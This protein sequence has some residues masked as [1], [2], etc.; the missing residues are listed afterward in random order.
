MGPL[1]LAA[2]AGGAL[3]WFNSRKPKRNVGTGDDN[4]VIEIPDPPTD[5]YKPGAV[6]TITL[7]VEDGKLFARDFEEPTSVAYTAGVFPVIASATDPWL[8]RLEARHGIEE[9]V[10]LDA[11][12]K[13]LGRGKLDAL[14]ELGL[15]VPEGAPLRLNDWVLEIAVK[16]ADGRI[17]PTYVY[18]V[19]SL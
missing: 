6:R 4:R 3:M 17:H 8:L 7:D 13:I 2:I 10:R 16:G 18:A 14:L 5:P 12:G 9:I 1:T 15:S 11:E 19:P